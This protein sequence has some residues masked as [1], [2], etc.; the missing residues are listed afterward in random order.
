MQR[1]LKESTIKKSEGTMD[2]RVNVEMMVGKIKGSD[3]IGW[4]Q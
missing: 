4:S 2:S 1:D 3:E